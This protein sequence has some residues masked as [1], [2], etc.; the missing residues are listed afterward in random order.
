MKTKLPSI[1]R[2]GLI[3]GL[4]TSLGLIAY[5]M[6]MKALNLAHIIELRM[7]NFV[8]IAVG[9]CYGINK[10]KHKLHQEGFYLQGIA[11]GMYIALVAVSSFALFMSIYLSYF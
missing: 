5:F 6:I 4:L 7:F 9:V 2:I 10:L 11:Q 8:I 3:T 1:E